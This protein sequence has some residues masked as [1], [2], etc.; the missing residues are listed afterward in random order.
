MTLTR[1]LAG[2]TACRTPSAGSAASFPG[3]PRLRLTVQVERPHGRARPAAPPRPARPAVLLARRD[4]EV[5][6]LL[7]PVAGDA[8]PEAAAH[9]VARDLRLAGL[10]VADELVEAGR[11]LALSSPSPSRYSIAAWMLPAQSMRKSRRLASYCIGRFLLP[12]SGAML[13]GSRQCFRRC[14]RTSRG[15]RSPG[16]TRA[17]PVRTSVCRRPRRAT[18]RRPIPRP[19]RWRAPS[20][21]PRVCACARRPS[22]S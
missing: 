17:G 19:T 15:S 4:D 20:R 6:G 21:S 3:E 2:R 22:W 5:V 11:N 16:R 8:E 12:P 10:E 13:S 7:D 18:G 9:R 14:Y 1:R